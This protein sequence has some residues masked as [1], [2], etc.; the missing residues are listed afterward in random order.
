M[1]LLAQNELRVKR[2]RYFPKGRTQPF[3][4]TFIQALISFKRLAKR[5]KAKI[6]STRLLYDEDRHKK[7]YLDYEVV[8]A[9]NTREWAKFGA[10]VITLTNIK[11]PVLAVTKYRDADTGQYRMVHLLKHQK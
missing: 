1:R 5:L 3:V 4:V 2:S 7:T 11:P 8:K 9:H 6:V 10:S